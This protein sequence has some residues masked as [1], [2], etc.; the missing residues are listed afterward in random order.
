M[1]FTLGFLLIGGHFLISA[2]IAKSLGGDQSWT[3]LIVFIVFAAS[4]GVIVI[5]IQNFLERVMIRRHVK[6]RPNSGWR[7]VVSDK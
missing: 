5:R 6:G 2:A 3:A 7:V 1:I 4:S